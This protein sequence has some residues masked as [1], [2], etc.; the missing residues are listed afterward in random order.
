MTDLNRR[1]ALKLLTRM[2][3]GLV[4]SLLFPSLA[5][6][7][8][9][10]KYQ[11][12]DFSKDSEK[13][14]LAR[15]IYGEARILFKDEEDQREPIMIGFTPINRAKDRIK[16]N[17]TNLKEAILANKI[18]KT[19]AGNK[20]RVYQYSCFNSRDPNLPKLKNPEKYDV[21]SWDK[22]LNLAD[23]ILRGKYT[24]LNYGQSHYHGKKMEKYP[25]WASDA[26]MKKIWGQDFFKH[27][28]YKDVKA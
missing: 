26:R 24:H 19:K 3:T 20:I 23:K 6:A 16:G 7:A 1:E 17:G 21:K 12:K 22:S 28:F 9:R 8:P 10:N 18:R 5:S 15:L 4:G 11:T 27:L 14:L 25:D 2:G 13:V